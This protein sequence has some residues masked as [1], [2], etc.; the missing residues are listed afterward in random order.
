MYEERKEL[1]EESKL[2]TQVNKEEK[3]RYLS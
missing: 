3:L 1:L 2:E